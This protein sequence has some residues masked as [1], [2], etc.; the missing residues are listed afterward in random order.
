MSFFGAGVFFLLGPGFDHFGELGSKIPVPLLHFIAFSAV[1]STEGRVVEPSWEHFKPK[2][3]KGPIATYSDGYDRSPGAVI[4][5]DLQFPRR[6]WVHGWR[7]R[8]GEDPTI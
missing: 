8:I 2:G 4:L 5:G 1:L 6:V 7:E 3:P